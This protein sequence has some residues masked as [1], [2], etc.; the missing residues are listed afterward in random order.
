MRRVRIIVFV[1]VVG[2]LAAAAAT[3][4]SYSSFDPCEWMAQDL[5]EHRGMPLVMARTEI[6]G[7]FLVNG[8]A[9]PDLGECMLAWWRFRAE[10]GPPARR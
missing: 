4:V 9:E 8:V 3:F 1:L 6:R 10:E 7:R 2:V 5:A